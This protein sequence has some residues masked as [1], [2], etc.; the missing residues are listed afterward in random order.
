[1]FLT[2][3]GARAGSQTPPMAGLPGIYPASHWLGL[4][5]DRASDLPRD[6]M[7]IYC[8]DSDTVEQRRDRIASLARTYL[9]R[10]GDG[11]V[12][13]AR[14]PGRVNLL[15]R[16]IDHQGGYCN[17]LAIERDLYVMAGLRADPKL[18][19]VNLEPTRFGE[20]SS[21]IR[22]ILPGYAGEPW[23][24]YVDSQPVRDQATR[25]AGQWQQYVKAPLARFMAAW[26]DLRWT[27]LNVAAAGDV[28]VAAGLSSSSA[29]VVS[30][31]EAMAA[32]YGINLA[33]EVFAETCG[34]AEWYV[35]ARGGSGDQAAMKFARAGCIVQ[36]GFHPMK[37]GQAAPWPPG[38]ALLVCNSGIE[39]R[40]SAGARNTFNQ[41]VASY[42]LA[43][44][45]VRRAHPEIADRVIHLRDLT[46]YHLGVSDADAAQYLLDIPARISRRHIIEELGESIAGP[47]LASH[48]WE[49]GEY[50]LRAVAAF[51]LAECER[52][53]QCADL[54]HQGD[55]DR[56]G[57]LMRI[58][59]DGDRVTA[60]ADGVF[61]PEGKC[62]CD[63]ATRELIGR[64]R[65][66]MH[67]AEEPGAYACSTPEI[68]LMVDIALAV[69][70][71]V[72]AQLSG[73]GLGGCMMVL[74]HE[75]AIPGVAAALE[76]SYYAPREQQP[77]MQVCRPV[78]GSGTLMS[79][80]RCGHNL[81][82]G[83][84]A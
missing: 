60:S 80:G 7:A 30:V 46:P 62:Y 21:N 72:G 32:L 40:K 53:R 49:S 47:F 29:L 41:R 25:D 51:G 42:H 84:D 20:A 52:S 12:V 27:G 26:P 9:S 76:Q 48:T 2:P 79:D 56:V 63:E 58:S 61:G 31:A 74:A 37:V 17:M 13:V 45:M 24:A 64:C 19:M 81:P 11:P 18:L 44:E 5:S 68:D 35:G 54:L 8:S 43:R 15:G 65:N 50:A 3:P 23:R 66:G 22:E 71:V 1:M 6:L 82:H 39:A 33:P 34:E 14:A 77:D 75:S 73:A 83:V 70:G 69:P 10:F 55:V 36:I 4:A 59:H 16:H 28:P 57:R 78:A 38:Y 67:L